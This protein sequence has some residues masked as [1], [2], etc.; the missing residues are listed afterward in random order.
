MLT[1]RIRIPVPGSLERLN[2]V[3]IARSNSPMGVFRRP[4]ANVD[5]SLG[6]RRRSPF[7][8]SLR[9]RAQG[10]PDPPAFERCH[11]A[12]SSHVLPPREILAPRYRVARR[13]VVT[14]VLKTAIG[15]DAATVSGSRS[16]Y[17]PAPVIS[18]GVKTRLPAPGYATVVNVIS[19]S[20]T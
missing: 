7:R 6:P 8:S 2:A 4:E 12:G 11:D 20:S 9:S 3:T 17:V 18:V 10:R 14:G 15:Y 1:M 5:R 16:V 13:A 19:R